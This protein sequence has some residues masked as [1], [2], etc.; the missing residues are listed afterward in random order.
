[1]TAC[2]RPKPEV[3]TSSDQPQAPPVETANAPTPPP[4]ETKSAGCGAA[5]QNDAVLPRIVVHSSSGSV[6][7][8]TFT[9]VTSSVQSCTL[10]VGGGGLRAFAVLP[11]GATEELA[12]SAL[13]VENTTSRQPFWSDGQL[14]FSLDSADNGQRQTIRLQGP[15]VPGRAPVDISLTLVRDYPTVMVDVRQAEGAWAPLDS[16]KS[17]ASAPTDLRFRFSR[18]VKADRLEAQLKQKQG[19]TWKWADPTTLEVHL[20][21]PPEKFELHPGG[22]PDS[23]GTGTWAGPAVLYTGKGGAQ[24]VAVDPQ[25][26]K[27]S[28][29]AGAPPEISTTH[30]S[31]D[32]RWLAIS[33]MRP[34]PDVY[35][36]GWRAESSL[37]DLQ[38]GKMIDLPGFTVYTWAGSV[39]LGSPGNAGIATYDPQTG[40]QVHLSS[41]YTSYPS[42]DGR[43]V[44]GF[45]MRW[46]EEK[47]DSSLIPVDL[48]VVDVNRRQERTFRGVGSYWVCHCD[49]GGAGRSPLLWDG[50]KVVIRDYSSRDKWRWVSVDIA[51]GAVQE[52]DT[53]HAEALEGAV[54]SP[55]SG[56]LGKLAQVQ[57]EWGAVALTRPDGTSVQLGPGKPV[58]WSKDGKA[59]L[60]R[61]PGSHL[62]TIMQSGL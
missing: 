29:V 11:S 15:L 26:G 62:R 12:K 9:S 27:E 59:L 31:P 2:S 33:A 21:N 45:I 35:W 49:G 58:G 55:L 24:L 39:L 17:Y 32:G 37:I 16:R 40:Q 54:S 5:Q 50:T 6:D 47:R 28:V 23:S 10:T 34:S 20:Q 56:P 42:P 3:P 14:N 60:I 1:M 7:Y 38:T 22:L 61:W 57:D 8:A 30:L 36:T 44:A 53:T 41:S 43:Y 13:K 52:V 51:T 46:S 18:A 19:I 25:T 48:V 4:I